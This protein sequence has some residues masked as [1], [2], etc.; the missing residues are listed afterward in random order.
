VPAERI[1]HRKN[2]AMK[3]HGAFCTSGGS[4][5]ERDD[6]GI[7]GSGRDVVECSRMSLHQHVE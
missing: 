4:R 7:V 6:R 3:M 5:R 2:V 1:G